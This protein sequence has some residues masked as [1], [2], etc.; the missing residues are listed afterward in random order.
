MIE[1]RPVTTKSDLREFIRL[2]RKIYR[3][4]PEFV[5]PLDF[6][7]KKLLHPSNG[8]FFKNGTARY[9]LAWQNGAAVGRI[10]AQIDKFSPNGGAAAIGGF[11]CLDAVDNSEV[12]SKLLAASAQWLG[13]HGMT[14]IRGPFTLSINGES[15]VQIEGQRERAMIWMP[16]HPTYLASHIGAAGFA[17]AK[18]LLAFSLR[19]PLVPLRLPAGLKD[20]IRVRELSLRDLKRDMDI[21]REI[22]N[23]AWQHN[24]GFIPLTSSE[25]DAL[26]KSFRPF[27]YKECG[28]FAEKNGEPIAFCFFAPNLFDIMRD[29]NGKLLPFN[30]VKFAWRVIRPAYRSARLM[31]LGVRDNLQYTVLGAMLPLILINEALQRWP[32]MLEEIELGWVLED[33][34]RVLRL[35]NSSGC[36]LT[37]RYRIYEKSL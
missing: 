21:M 29:F 25:M 27:L 6:E 37:K 5:P 35:L 31:L 28:L 34:T 8:S 13:S 1:I 10:S 3:R 15:G 30:W 12:V 7:R 9:W 19:K 20:S 16:W 11:G 32:H 22:F 33:N 4:F 24:W 26:R 23:S 14:R 18:D 17:Q 36:V 2:P